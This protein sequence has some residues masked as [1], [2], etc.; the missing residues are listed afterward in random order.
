LI[1]ELGR[2]RGMFFAWFLNY[3]LILIE[4]KA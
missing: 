1:D 2:T 3:K 4:K